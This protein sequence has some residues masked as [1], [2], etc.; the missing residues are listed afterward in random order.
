VKPTPRE[1]L[2]AAA[3]TRVPEDLNLYPRLSSQLE[4]KSW[5]QTLRAKPVLLILSVLLALTLLTGVAYA[6]GRL[7]GFIPGFGFTGDASTVYML[8]EPVQVEQDGITIRVE[9]AV[10]AEDKFWVSL[11]LQGTYATDQTLF[12]GATVILSDGTVLQS[13]AGQ[14]GDQNADP[15]QASYEFPVLPSGTDALTFH[16]EFFTRDAVIVWKA[17]IPIKLRPIRAEEVIPAPVTQSA[18]LQSETHEGVTLVLDHVAAASDK[19]ILEVSLRFDQPGTSLNTFWGI[20]LTSDEGTIYPL[21]E[22]LSDSNNQSKTFE[23]LPF[24]GGETLTLSLAAFPDAQALPMSVDFPVDQAIFTFDPGANPQ[25]GQSWELDEQVQVGKYLVHVISARQVSLTELLFEFGPTPGVTGVALYSPSINGG[26]G[27]P[28]VE[29]ANYTARLFFENVPVQPITITVTRVHYTARGQ[30]QIQWHA[31]AAPA[32]VIVGP[33]NTPPP[34]AAMFATPTI[35]SSDPFLQEVQTL[36][37]TFD[38]PFRQGAGWVHL[39]S[40]SEIYLRPGQTFPPPYLTSEQ[41]LELDAEGYVIRTLRTDRDQ[42]GNIIQQVV[43]I[44]NYFTNFTTGESGYNEYAR[45]PFSTDMLTNDL[46]QAAQYQ[47]QV[48]REE[49]P[50][51]DGSPC[52]LI[53]LFDAFDQAVQHPEEPQPILGMGRKTWVNLRTGQQVKVQAFSWLQDGSDKIEHTERTLLVEK[54]DRPPEDVLTIING[55]VVP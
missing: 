40:E 11:S 25:V 7:T 32:G 2:D 45:Y 53:T 38:V 27:S 46:I 13:R 19:T 14:E 54:L 16:Y 23:T 29:N 22:I 42:D 51:D 28:P 36:A 34:T 37:Q 26:T 3:R 49:L 5:M 43:T 18:P 4:R 35:T 50:C 48:T 17:D 24:R 39:V 20:N 15:R 10:S 12:P 31:P 21:T 9:N 41:W 52:L 47:S 1:L 55:V 33:T 6:V 8:Q 44:G 30:W